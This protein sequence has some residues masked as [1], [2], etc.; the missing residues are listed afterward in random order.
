[1]QTKIMKFNQLNE[2][3]LTSLGFREIE[4][5]SWSWGTRT[6]DINMQHDEYHNVVEPGGRDYV[7]IIIYDTECKLA[8]VN[9]NKGSFTK[10]I[11]NEPAMSKLIDA[12]SFLIGLES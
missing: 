9:L 2:V 5:N 10:V 6:I 7:P 12:A 11:V 3:M 8:T 1:M 4:N